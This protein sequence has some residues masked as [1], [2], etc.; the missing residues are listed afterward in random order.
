MDNIVIQT[1]NAL[2]DNNS[3]DIYDMCA[4]LQRTLSV[5]Q[6]AQ[7][8]L[9]LEYCNTQGL[10]DFLLTGNTTQLVV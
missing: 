1:R 4:A 3:D 10:V 5:Q 9:L 8:A 6:R 7:I 2:Q